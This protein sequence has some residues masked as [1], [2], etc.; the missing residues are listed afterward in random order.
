MKTRISLENMIAFLVTTPMFEDLDPREV[1]EIVHIVETVKYEPGEEIFSEGEPGDAWYAL[2]K[3]EVEILKQSNEGQKQIRTLQPP[4]CFGEVAILD[5][6]PR[7]ATVRA[8]KETVA[9][10]ITSD[11]L[12]EL[13]DQEHLVA[14]KLIRYMA[15][16]LVNELRSNTEVLSKLLNTNNL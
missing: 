9:L 2:Y 8:T 16:T 7:S 15:L 11:K 6:L 4:S 13:V 1:R 5:G 3:G 12:Q 14:Y 10:R